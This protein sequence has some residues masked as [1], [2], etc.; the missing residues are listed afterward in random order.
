MSK[1]LKV[2]IIQQ[3]NTADISDNRARLAEKM[4]HLA[5]DA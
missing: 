5:Q 3:N 2:G 1:I 4:R